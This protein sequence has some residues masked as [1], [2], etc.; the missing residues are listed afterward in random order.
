[1]HKKAKAKIALELMGK[2][3]VIEENYCFNQF[4]CSVAFSHLNQIHVFFYKHNVYK[5]IQAQGYYKKI[6][7]PA[8][9]DLSC[10]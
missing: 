8:S 9:P 7:I 2:V 4:K 10:H 3:S 6:S 5:H 1:M